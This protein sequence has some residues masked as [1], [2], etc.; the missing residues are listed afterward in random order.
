MVCSMAGSCI[1]SLVATY[2]KSL[3]DVFFLVNVTTAAMALGVPVITSSVPVRFSAFLV[4]ETCVGFYYPFCVGTLKSMHV[5][6]IA[7]LCL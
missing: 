1:Y 5:Q 7:C 6:D 2:W 3:V 4:F